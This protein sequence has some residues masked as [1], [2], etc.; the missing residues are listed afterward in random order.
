MLL[1]NQKRTDWFEVDVT[2]SMRPRSGLNIQIGRCVVPVKRGG[3]PN[4]WAPS[5]EEQTGIPPLPVKTVGN[6]ARYQENAAGDDRAAADQ[7]SSMDG[8]SKGC[9]RDSGRDGQDHGRRG[10]SPLS[11]NCR[12]ISF[13]AAR[14]RKLWLARFTRDPPAAIS[15]HKAWP[16]PL[17]V[18]RTSAAATLCR[19]RVTSGDAARNRRRDERRDP[20]LMAAVAEAQPGGGAGSHASAGCGRCAAQDQIGLPSREG[21]A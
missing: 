17:T 21:Y 7:H 16:A 1:I 15:A 8:P 12:G 2:R 19:F 14:L 9:H 13:L 3:R 10:L 18:A 6:L 5:A 11:N 4:L 20:E